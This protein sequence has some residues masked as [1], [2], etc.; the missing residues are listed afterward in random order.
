MKRVKE[1]NYPDFLEL[2]G[3]NTC[4]TVYPMAIAGRMQQGKRLK[5]LL[6]KQGAMTLS[7][8]CRRDLIP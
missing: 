4:N 1:E 5:R 8:S 2:A 3:L 7:C 6:K